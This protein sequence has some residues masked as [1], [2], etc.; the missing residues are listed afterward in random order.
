MSNIEY[1]QEKEVQR[2][3]NKK[4]KL[5]KGLEAI[6]KEIE[7]SKYILD[8]KDKYND[9]GAEK[10]DPEIWEESIKLVIRYSKYVYRGY[11]KIIEA[12]KIFH[13]PD[14]SIDILWE[15]KKEDM[16]LININ[17]PGG[18]MFA[19]YYGCLHDKTNEIRDKIPVKPI[20]KSLA[21]W[22]KNLANE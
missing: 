19:S 21:N 20:N 2:L 7:K 9:E 4:F 18:K 8:L 10:I 17:K 14:N 6:A 12:P 16:L 13:G 15:T 3:K 5:S 22:M 1:N 11:N